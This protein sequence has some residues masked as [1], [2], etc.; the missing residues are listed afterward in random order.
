LEDVPKMVAQY[1][2]DTAFFSTNCGMQVPL[3]KAVYD[4]GAYYPSPCDP[5]P[6]HGF[7][8]ALGI[9]VPAD[10]VGGMQDVIDQTNRKVGSAGLSG[11]FSTWPVPAAMMGTIGATEYALMWMDGKTNG[12]VDKAALTRAMSAY[13]GVDISLVTYDIN[14]EKFDNYFFFI[15]D[16][17]TYGI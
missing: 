9:N 7:P 14:E 10:L 8:A 13:A 2:K 5:S 17:L 11:H 3:I 1:G 6:Y 16:F 12:K 15:L 4:T